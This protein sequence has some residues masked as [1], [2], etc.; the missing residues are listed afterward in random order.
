[1]NKNEFANIAAQLRCL[2]DPTRL[3]LVEQLT[4][5]KRLVGVQGLCRSLKLPQPTVSHHLGLLRLNGVVE[6]RRKGKQV[7]YSLR[8]GAL[9]MA[10]GWVGSVIRASN[11]VF[12]GLPRSA[13]GRGTAA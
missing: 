11:R 4:A 8:P 10:Y 9:S 12:P 6:A 13:G 2:A 7:F 3:R 1:M 5:N